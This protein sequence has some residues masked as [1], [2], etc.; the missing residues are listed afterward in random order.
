MT[1]DLVLAALNMA[2]E[3]RKP[4]DVIHDSDQGS[5]YTRL[6]FGGR[7]QAM[8]A[9][10]SMSIVGDGYGNAMPESF[11]ANLEFE[12][13]NRRSFESKA[14]ARMAIFTWIEG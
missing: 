3:Q 13:I 6:A 12:L 1:V 4:V 2:L 10:P 11:F 9:R 14:E 7:C 5:Q 8:G